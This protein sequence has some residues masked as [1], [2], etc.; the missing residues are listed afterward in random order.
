MS[1]EKTTATPKTE[2]PANPFTT[3]FQAFGSMDPMKI[4]SEGHAQFTKLMTDATSRWQSFADQY[5][6]VEQ[7]MTA[8][9]QTAVTNWAQLAKD[10]IA[11]GVQLSTEARK[12]SIE[13]AKKMGVQA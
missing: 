4:W 7:Q 10:A 9:A 11:Y 3:P 2:T 6:A 1:N 13:T 5:V 8:Q 12:L